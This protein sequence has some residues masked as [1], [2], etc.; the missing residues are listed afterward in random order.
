MEEYNGWSNYE[1]WNCALW[2]NNDAGLYDYV[3]NELVNASCDPD[4]LAEKIKD[5]VE[6]NMPKLSSMYADILSNALG[7]I[8]YRE[9]I[10]TILEE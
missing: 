2:I 6:E 8:N 7:R 5:M 10:K 3:Y 9:I 1:T 4:Q